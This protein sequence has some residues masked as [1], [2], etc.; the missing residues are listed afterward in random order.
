MVFKSTERVDNMSEIIWN[1]LWDI[2]WEMIQY[3]AL[4]V[5]CLSILDIVQV[6]AHWVFTCTHALFPIWL[7]C[8][9][10]LWASINQ[11]PV[12]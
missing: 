1:V 4:L 6:F 9:A 7:R 3:V 8:C 11:G 12:S 5:W 10:V 2:S